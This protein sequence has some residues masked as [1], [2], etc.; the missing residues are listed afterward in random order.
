M[1]VATGNCP[2]CGAPIEFAL[3]SSL[4][5]VCDY[6]R[7]T[8]LRSDRGLEN[9]G[10]V[11]DLALTP[12]L[13]AVGD[14]GTL[15]GRPFRVMGRTQ[16]DHGKGPWDEY[17]VAFEGG[18]SWGFL[19]YAQGEWYVTSAAAGALPPFESLAPEQDLSLNGAFFRVAEVK[20]GTVTSTEGELPGLI[21]PGLARSYADCYGPNGAFATLDYGDGSSAPT[22]FAG[23]VFNEAAMTVTA[24]GPRTA[25]KIKT[26]TLKCPN[27]GGDVPKLSGERAERL[28]CPY[29]GAISDLAGQRVISAQQAARAAAEIPIGTHGT[30]EGVS[31]LCI[32]YMRRGTSFE[33]EPYSWDEYLLFSESLGF[34]WLV[35]DP[36]AGWSFVS[37]VNLAEIDLRG[38]PGVVSYHGRQFQLR[39]TNTARV[40]Y[41]LGEVYWKCELGEL[42]SVSDFARGD[43]VLSREA[44][45]GEVRWSLATAVPW[46]VLARAFN[47]AVGGAGS[48][49][50]GYGSSGPKKIPSALALLLVIGLIILVA[51]AEGM[52]GNGGGGGGVPVGGVFYGGK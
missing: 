52:D 33:G 19:A 36:E 21:R 47:L 14:E 18:Q 49:F 8:V 37:P 46:P 23:W 20:R 41:V 35:K 39:N 13:I 4:A 24:L 34:R 16:L 38:L 32:A 7:H 9:L 6:C 48:R 1:P 11:A 10:K 43:D 2:N 27:C 17:Y 25:Q 26:A 12:S 28:G 45:D 42:T 15:G 31:Y 51:A 22:L 29:C 3:G 40:E 50:G 30:L 44:G 5:K